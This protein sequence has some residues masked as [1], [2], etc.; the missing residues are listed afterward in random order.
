MG[1]TRNGKPRNITLQSRPHIWLLIATPITS[2][3]VL[4]RRA[5]Q[6]GRSICL[7]YPKYVY[8]RHMANYSWAIGRFC[9]NTLAQLHNQEELAINDE[10]ESKGFV[11]MHW[12]LMDTIAWTS[13]RGIYWNIKAANPANLFYKFSLGGCNFA[14]QFPCRHAMAWV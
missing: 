12:L 13:Y 5:N 3:Y 10:C 14:K 8:G 6:G 4:H 9:S 11:F 2:Y 1:Y 7:I